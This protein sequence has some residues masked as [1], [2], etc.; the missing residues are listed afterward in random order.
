[1]A[2][3]G[4]G[5]QYESPMIRNMADEVREVRLKFDRRRSK[6]IAKDRD[7]R[8]GFDDLRM[9]RELIEMRIWTCR[10]YRKVVRGC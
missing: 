9:G 1:M 7:G 3:Q 8:G 6:S 10:R 5:G 2:M 4:T